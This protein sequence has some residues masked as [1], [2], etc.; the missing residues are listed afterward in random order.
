[1]A[2]KI[3]NVDFKGYWREPN[4]RGIPEESGVYCVYECKHNVSNKTVTI[5]RLIY[6]GESDNVNERI[7]NHEKWDEWKQ[8]VGLGRELCF[9]FG[10]VESTYR[11]RVEA[12]LIYEHKPPVNVEYKSCFP[13]DKTTVKTSGANSKL[14]TEFTV[15]RTL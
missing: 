6:I 5:H 14:K 2:E 8:Y 7:K 10:Y 3:F 15:L 13:F 4:I 1:M 11:E 12:A 9:S